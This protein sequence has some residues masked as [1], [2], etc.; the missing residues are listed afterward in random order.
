MRLPRVRLRTLMIAVAVVGVICAAVVICKARR[1]RFERIA[2]RHTGVF[3][4]LSFADAM[5]PDYERRSRWGREVMAWHAEMARKYR[6]AARSPWLP[7]TPEPPM[8]VPP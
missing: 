4:P 1:E 7:I 8:P 3:P 6:R 2:A 5:S